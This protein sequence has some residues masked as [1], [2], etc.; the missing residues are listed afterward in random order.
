MTLPAILSRRLDWPVWNLGFAGNALMDP[1]LAD[2]FSRIV[3]G[4]AMPA[5]P[6][7][8]TLTVPAGGSLRVRCGIWLVSVVAKELPS[9]F[10]CRSYGICA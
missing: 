4:P 5:S 3:P 8:H 1:E 9:S 6:L 10:S 2:F 7:C